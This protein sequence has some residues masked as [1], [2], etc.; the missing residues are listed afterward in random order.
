MLRRNS[1][2]SWATVHTTASLVH[3]PKHHHQQNDGAAV[4]SHHMYG[5][6]H[7]HLTDA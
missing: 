5:L 3:T 2:A 6:S 4:I 1:A 7:L